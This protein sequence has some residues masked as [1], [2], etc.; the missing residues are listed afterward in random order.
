MEEFLQ[1]S[2]HKQCCPDEIASEIDRVKDAQLHDEPCMPGLCSN[3]PRYPHILKLVRA[4]S[5]QLDDHK[6]RTGALLHISS[7]SCQ[8]AH[9]VYL[10]VVV[11]KPFLQTLIRARI[12]DGQ[13]CFHLEGDRLQV[14][15]SHTTFAG[16]MK[17]AEQASVPF[18]DLQL[19]VEVWHWEPFVDPERNCLQVLAER[20]STTFELSCQAL[21]EKLSA[22]AAAKAKSSDSLPFGMALEKRKRKRKPKQK[23]PQTGSGGGGGGGAPGSSDQHPPSDQQGN[24]LGIETI[25]VDP[26]ESETG[27]DSNNSSSSAS[28]ESDWEDDTDPVEPISETMK[29]EA[30][31]LKSVAREI[32]EADKS[33]ADAAAAASKSSAAAGAGSS[34]FSRELGLGSENGPAVTGRSKCHSCHTLIPVGSTRFQW[35]WNTKKPNGWLH[36]YCVLNAADTYNMRE[37][38]MN[39][40]KLISTGA[41]N[42]SVQAAARSILDSVGIC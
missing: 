20:V 13:A 6:I 14:Q 10:G 39:K 24:G 23:R 38:T 21:H 35:W 28:S 41:D 7:P 36:A 12:G 25:D 3:D 31:T 16:M 2:I 29:A 15:T 32:T 33:K 1:N 34:F 8:T 4:F 42:A 40:L 5:K 17:E 18:S 19:F 37:S 9:T 30:S 27:S 26:S 22:A 11:K